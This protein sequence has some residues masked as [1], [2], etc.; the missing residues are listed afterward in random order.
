MGETGDQAV[1]I[2]TRIYHRKK[3]D[4]HHNKR[5]GNHHKRQKKFRRDPYSF[6][7]YTC[8][9]KGYYS[10]YFP[11]NRCSFNKKSNKKRHHAHTIEDDEPT[12]KIFKEVNE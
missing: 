10:K 2:H 7:C 8:D 11:R 3:E 1:T 5:E 6:R 4:H 12:N 9:E